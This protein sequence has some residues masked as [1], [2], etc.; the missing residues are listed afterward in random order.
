M[1]VAETLFAFSLASVLMAITPG[2][3]TALVLRTAAAEGPAR[4]ALVSLGIVCGCLTWGATVALGLGALLQAYPPAFEAIKLA[5]AAYLSWLGLKLL[6]VRRGGAA[7]ETR[8]R[9]QGVIACMRRGYVTNVLNP[10]AGL[11]YMSFLPQFVHPSM[12][13]TSFTL[14]LAGLHAIISLAW[15]VLLTAFTR[16]V[17]RVLQAPPVILWLDRIMGTLFL[18]FGMKLAL[19]HG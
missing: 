5:G 4:A 13:A 15:F 2:V 18:M 10:K 1:T 19:E 16:S 6:L 9:R 12:P 8:T 3:D 17:A 14:I 7:G 11:F